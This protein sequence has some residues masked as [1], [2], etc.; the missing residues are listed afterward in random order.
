MSAVASQ[1]DAKAWLIDALGG[2]ERRAR[3]VTAEATD[4]GITP[5]RL[6]RAREAVC[7]DPVQRDGAWHWRLRDDQMPGAKPVQS[8]N[9][10]QS[11]NP[12]AMT[13][14]SAMTVSL[15]AEGER[16]QMPSPAGSGDASSTDVAPSMDGKASD[17][18]VPAPGPPR[19]MVDAAVTAAEHAVQPVRFGPAF[20]RAGWVPCGTGL[21]WL[22]DLR[23]AHVAATTGW[24]RAVQT[25]S[26]VI[27]DSERQRAEYEIVVERALRMGFEPPSNAGLDP[28]VRDARLRLADRGLVGA[29]S[30]LS[31]CVTTTVAVVSQRRKELGPWLSVAYATGLTGDESAAM[32]RVS[33]RVHQFLAEIAQMG[34][35]D[36][37]R[38]LTE[39]R[40]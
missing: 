30:D 15:G 2:G 1:V 21:Q 6:R 39:W 16:M 12:H 13:V 10:R 17:R 27:A 28:D 14:G 8:M 36:V 40:A 26:M 4:A 38:E 32:R 25:R 29:V 18:Q 34:V 19:W 33:D 20:G 3:D 37:Q 24:V 31:R 23:G 5:K 9:E 35:M 11:M 22:D 7:A